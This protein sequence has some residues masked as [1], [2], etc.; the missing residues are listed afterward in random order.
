VKKLLRK[1]KRVQ[2]SKGTKKKE[3]KR[4]KRKEKRALK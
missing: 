2:K 4:A 1:E 3:L